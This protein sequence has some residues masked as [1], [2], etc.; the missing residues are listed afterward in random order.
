MDFIL[1]KRESEERYL[2]LPS[3][4][5]AAG[6]PRVFIEA[7]LLIDGIMEVF[8]DFTLAE[9]ARDAFVGVVT[10]LGKPD[11]GLIF[12][13]VVRTFFCSTSVSRVT[14]LAEDVSS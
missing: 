9:R 5:G 1:P 2:L 3:V 6:L 12:T 10:A 8:I 4:F 13:D 14:G 11:G 7:D